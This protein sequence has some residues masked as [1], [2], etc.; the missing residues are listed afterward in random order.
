MDATDYAILE[1]LRD[2][3]RMQ[4]KEIGERVH[5]T[6]PAVANRIARLEELGVLQGYTTRVDE[7]KLGR[8][9]EALVTVFLQSNEHTAFRDWALGESAV[10]EL[11]RV[12]GEGCYWMKLRH[13][14]PDE[15]SAL[16][17]RLI[18]FGNYRVNGSIGRL[19]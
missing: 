9:F 6:G 7:A 2:N 17:E 1:A 11:H 4:W 18:R 3:A 12:T 5:L 13:R 14:D 16:L 19:K 8:S 10:T 15:L